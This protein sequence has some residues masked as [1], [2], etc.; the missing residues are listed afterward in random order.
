VFRLADAAGLFTD[1]G[2]S[3]SRMRALCSSYGIGE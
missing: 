1:P 2:R 3:A